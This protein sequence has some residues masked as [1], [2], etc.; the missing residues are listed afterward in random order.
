MNK[1]TAKACAAFVISLALLALPLQAKEAASLAVDETAEKRMVA[2]ADELRCLVCQN[3]SLSASHADLANDL[4]REIRALMK[5]GKSD[6]EILDFMVDRYGDFVRYRPPLKG[7]TLILWFGPALLLLIG[8]AALIAYLRRR[9]DT[10]VDAAL[11]PEEQQQAD[12]L[13]SNKDAAQ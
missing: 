4:R 2:I 13:L 5:D 3:E 12:R 10:I 8:L 7:T 1:L 6:A 9:N 11:T